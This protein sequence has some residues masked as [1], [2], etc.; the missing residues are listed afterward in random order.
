MRFGLFLFTILTIH[1][2]NA[3]TLSADRSQKQSVCSAIAE[4]YD[5][6][7]DVDTLEDDCQ[8]Q[9]NL[10]RIK[11]DHGQIVTTNKD[12]EYIFE[13]K[14]YFGLGGLHLAKGYVLKSGKVLIHESLFLS[15]F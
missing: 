11:T 13:A 5:Y 14:V 7:S 1:F 3:E 2:A 8:G 6:Y 12:A 4:E 15:S 9:V 10:I